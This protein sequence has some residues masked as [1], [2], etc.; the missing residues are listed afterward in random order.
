MFAASNAARSVASLR[1][2]YL[3]P[4]C[5]LCQVVWDLVREQVYT[6][7]THEVQEQSRSSMNAG[8]KFFVLRTLFNARWII[9]T[10]LL[11]SSARKSLPSVLLPVRPLGKARKVWQG[12]IR[13]NIKGATDTCECTVRSPCAPESG[14]GRTCLTVLHSPHPQAAALLRCVQ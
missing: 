8:V 1:Q 3:L 2:R 9:F 11:R 10:P 14:E 6:W 12:P 13:S 5:G 4:A 7:S